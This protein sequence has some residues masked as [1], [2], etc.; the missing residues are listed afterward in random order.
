M[1]ERLTDEHPV[2]R[3]PMKARK[4]SHVEQENIDP[5]SLPLGGHELRRRLGQR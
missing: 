1:D 4:A 3:V 2:E 5:V